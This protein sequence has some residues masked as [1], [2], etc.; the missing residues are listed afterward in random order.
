MVEDGRVRL[1]PS[2]PVHHVCPS[3]DLLFASPAR[4]YGADAAVVR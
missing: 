2:A 4:N 3:I 1:V